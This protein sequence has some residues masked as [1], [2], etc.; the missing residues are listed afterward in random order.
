MQSQ[1]LQLEIDLIRNYHQYDNMVGEDT[2]FPHHSI[3]A[4]QAGGAVTQHVRI[5]TRTSAYFAFT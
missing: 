4:R 3:A 5:C 1:C 2:L